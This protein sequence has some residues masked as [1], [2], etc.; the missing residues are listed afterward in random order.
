MT[1]VQA[2]TLK[3]FRMPKLALPTSSDRLSVREL[4]K[5]GAFLENLFPCP[6]SACSS[7]GVQKNQVLSNALFILVPFSWSAEKGKCHYTYEKPKTQKNP[8]PTPQK[9]NPITATT[10]QCH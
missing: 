9:K 2:S 7:H 8:K 3:Y 5:Q 6:L 4:R 1:K 10:Y